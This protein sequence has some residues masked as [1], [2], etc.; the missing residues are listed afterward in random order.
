M[1]G[2]VMSSDTSVYHF[3]VTNE[4]KDILGGSQLLKKK[5]WGSG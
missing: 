5:A 3:I 4:S 1:S 2:F